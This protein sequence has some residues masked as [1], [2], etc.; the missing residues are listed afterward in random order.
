MFTLPAYRRQ[1]YY[2]EAFD[3]RIAVSLANGYTKLIAVC[4]AKSLPEWIK[5]GAKITKQF[6]MFTAVE[7]ELNNPI[8]SIQTNFS[9]N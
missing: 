4:T 9:N 8:T 6:K 5:R 3:F 7:L 2:K 1:G